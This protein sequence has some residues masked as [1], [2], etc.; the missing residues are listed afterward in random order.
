MLTVGTGI[1]RAD[2]VEEAVLTLRGST[3]GP[4][5]AAARERLHGFLSRPSSNRTANERA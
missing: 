2:D 1:Y 4:G 5:D 3:Q